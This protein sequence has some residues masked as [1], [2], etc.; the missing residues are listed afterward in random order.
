MTHKQ[1]ISMS[2]RIT[3]RNDE[4]PRYWEPNPPDEL[5]EAIPCTCGGEAILRPAVGRWDTAAIVC[6]RRPRCDRCI[7]Y[8]MIPL[9]RAVELWN[10][11]IRS[12][13]DGDQ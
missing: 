8:T 9:S 6:S 10:N 4:D 12:E 3:A 7:P 5:D 11:D 2:E 1:F 13:Q